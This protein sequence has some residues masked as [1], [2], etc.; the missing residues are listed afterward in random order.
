MKKKL[1]QRTM[2]I[3]ISLFLTAALPATQA[4]GASMGNIVRPAPDEGV[5]LGDLGGSDGGSDNSDSGSS[6]GGSGNPDSGDS[7]GGSSNSDSG[8]SNGGSGDSDSGGSNGGS[9][10]ADSG[11]SNGGSHDSDSDGQNGGSNNPGAGDSHG[12]N[13]NSD[14]G[15]SEGGIGAGSDLNQDSGSPGAGESAGNGNAGSESG[16]SMESG[17][18]SESGNGTGL[19]GSTETGGST[20]PGDGSKPG[21]NG[22]EETSEAGDD[23]HGEGGGPGVGGKGTAPTEENTKSG[24]K[25]PDQTPFSGEGTEES[26]YLIQSAKD[27]ELLAKL[28]ISD[29]ETY[30]SGCY[31]LTQNIQMKKGGNNHTPIGSREQPFLGEFDGDGYEIAGLRINRP[32]K[33]LQGLFAVVGE[34]GAVRNVGLRDNRICGK[35]QVGAV[36]GFN[37]GTIESCFQTGEVFGISDSAGSIAGINSGTIQ[38]CYSTGMVYGGYRTGDYLPENPEDGLRRRAPRAGFR[39]FIMT[40]AETIAET[41][42][43]TVSYV[44]EETKSS[45]ETIYE[46]V[47]TAFSA[48][49]NQ[50]LS[51]EDHG[52]NLEIT[53]DE[54]ERGNEAG[55]S[56][57]ESEVS[58]TVIPEICE[59][60]NEI[61][62]TVPDSPGPGQSEVE[63]EAEISSEEF[64]EPAAEDGPHQP[65]IGGI[66]GRNEGGFVG[67]TYQAGRQETKDTGWLSG[68]ICGVN[69]DGMIDNCYFVRG[70][71]ED[72]GE[73]TD[74]E[75]CTAVTLE[76]ITGEE[77]AERMA[78]DSNIWIGK[79]TDEDRK[80]DPEASENFD[81]DIPVQY[82][83]YFPQLAVFADKGQIYPYTLG[84]IEADGLRVDTLSKKASVSTEEGWYW[85]FSRDAYLD[86]SITLEADLNLYGFNTSIGNADQPFTGI[87]DGN[88]HVITGLKRPLFGV[89]GEGAAVYYLLI[90]QAEITGTV[91]Y[92]RNDDQAVMS[93]CGV[94]AAYAQ[95]TVI[96]SCGVTGTITL[97][98]GAPGGDGLVV[99]GLIGETASGTSIYETYSFVEIREETEGPNIVS[100]GFIGLAGTDTGALNCYATGRLTCRGTTGGFAGE[101]RGEIRDSFATTIVSGS[102]GQTGAFVGIMNGADETVSRESLETVLLKTAWQEAETGGS[103]SSTET[104]GFPEEEPKGTEA[105]GSP[106]EDTKGTEETGSPAEDTKGSEATGFPAEDTKGMETTDFPAEEETEGVETS[107][108]LPKEKTTASPAEDTAPVSQETSASGPGTQAASSSNGQLTKIEPLRD[109]DSMLRG[110]EVL[111]QEWQNYTITGC[112]YDLQMS[113]CTDLYAE[114]LS[115]VEMTG[116]DALLSGGVWYRTEGAYPQ[117]MCMAFHTHETYILSSKASAIPLI[118]PN[119]VTMYDLSEGEEDQEETVKISGS[120]EVIIPP[121]IDGDAIQWSDP[122]QM[123]IQGDGKAILEVN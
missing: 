33:E 121:Q 7:N 90:D 77:A 17:S 48:E 9:G 94:L 58:E 18:G 74:P 73:R 54:S 5:G 57:T 50:D 107:D 47:T 85:L 100:G 93:G 64:E 62:E 25:E 32:R 76:R 95:G 51:T 66:V 56:E 37:Y 46:I 28:I 102:G 113:G 11:G 75:G 71:Y 91:S 24:E 108:A 63:S 52:D 6:G 106:A 20:Q 2:T 68:G 78:F 21:A 72:G 42:S 115:T 34:N 97:S 119:G 8:G 15:S 117:L 88:G 96:D 109:Q 35:E 3:G 67:S 26:P 118:L 43:E 53:A 81:S 79:Q 101:N 12:G 80:K 112:A 41:I 1:L 111:Y 36:A 45:L 105:T 65:A 4:L 110:N 29:Y 98:G 120:L 30:G 19:E 84:Y 59:T 123:T 99:G 87:L 103:A 16:D 82:R 114:G 44:I 31:R 70:T 61:L 55:E 13:G 14:S 116:E 22:P 69:R 60:V 27:L 38:D 104:T 39:D 86:Y 92:R 83:H 89:M 40:V 49:N 10:D 122:E 23:K